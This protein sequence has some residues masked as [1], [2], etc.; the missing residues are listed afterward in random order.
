MTQDYLGNP[1]DSSSE[2]TRQ[3]I[4]DFTG[5]MLAYQTRAKVSSPAPTASPDRYW[6]TLSP[7]CS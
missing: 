1:I 4:D 7:A 2:A 5:G 6:P 3:A